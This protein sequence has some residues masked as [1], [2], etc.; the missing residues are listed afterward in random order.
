MYPYSTSHTIVHDERADERVQ[1]KHFPG[2]HLDVHLD[3]PLNSFID[4]RSLYRHTNVISIV[5]FSFLN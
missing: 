1:R 5:A 4:K 3:V 2:I